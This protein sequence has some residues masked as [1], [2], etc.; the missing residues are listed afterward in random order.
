MLTYLIL[1]KAYVLAYCSPT[2][3]TAEETV[4]PTGLRHDSKAPQLA[5]LVFS[6]R[7]SG[8]S[9]CAVKYCH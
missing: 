2:H 5:E 1:T 4:G 3:I 7:S 8:L 9:D 6:P